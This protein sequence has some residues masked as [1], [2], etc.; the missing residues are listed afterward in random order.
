MKNSIKALSLSLVAAAVIAPTAQ[1]EITANVAL[2]TDYVWRGVSQN[3]DESPAL[4]GGF[5]FADESGFYAGVWASNVNFGGNESLELDIYGGWSTEFESGLGLDFGIIRYSYHGASDSSDLDFTEFY[6][7][8]SYAGF[9]FIYSVGDELGDQYELSYGYD[10]EAV[11]LAAAYGNYDA[12]DD[13]NDYDYY[14]LGVSG[15][16]GGESDLG[17]DVSY[18]GTSSEGEVQFGDL[19]DDRIVF[20]LSKEF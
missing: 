20:T 6:G 19:A 13:G 3:T 11:S 1:A 2:T 12:A 18:W 9:G 14:S 10:F 8:V 5:D 15:S 7:G 17:W 16:F 4:Q